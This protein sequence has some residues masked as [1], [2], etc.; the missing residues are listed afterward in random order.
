MKLKR[1]ICDYVR[2]LNI[3]A[4]FTVLLFLFGIRSVMFDIC[5]I[6]YLFFQDPMSVL[7]YHLT[8]NLLYTKVTGLQ[9]SKIV[10]SYN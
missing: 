8:L 1:I 7:K 9:S 3:H 10:F 6:L 2:T 5:C 4:K